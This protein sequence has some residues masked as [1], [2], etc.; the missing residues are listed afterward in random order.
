[1]SEVTVV[2]RMTDREAR[3]L[4]KALDDTRTRIANQIMA[5]AQEKVIGPLTVTVGVLG[6]VNAVVYEAL[7]SQS[8]RRA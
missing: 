3:L 8:P 4:H 2:F 1:M 5:E 6:R 7:R